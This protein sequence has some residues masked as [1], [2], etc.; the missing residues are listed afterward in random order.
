MLVRA[1]GKPY[2]VQKLASD[3]L[4]AVLKN[5]AVIVLPAFARWGMRLVRH[6]PALFE[7]H[8]RKLA[9]AGVTDQLTSEAE[10]SGMPFPAASA[11]RTRISNGSFRI[12]KTLPGMICIVTDAGDE[13]S[14]IASGTTGAG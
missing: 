12:A 4:D 1:A 6:A 13:L 7:A 11:R 5:E 14:I 3:A 9:P 2:P 10:L 8:V